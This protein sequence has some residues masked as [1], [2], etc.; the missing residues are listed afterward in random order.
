MRVSF[1][2]KQRLLSFATLSLVF[3]AIVSAT[4][5]WGAYQLTRAMAD[6]AATSS[7]Q[8]NETQANM[9]S[10]ALHGDVLAALQAGADKDESDDKEIIKNSILKDTDEHSNLFR[11]NIS[12]N[13]ALPLNQDIKDILQKTQPAVD[14]HIANSQSIIRLAFENNVAAN[15]SFKEYNNAYKILAGTMSALGELMDDTMRESQEAGDVQGAVIRNAI[16]VIMATVLFALVIISLLL[17]R[18][19]TRP[20]AKAV[21]L[22]NTVASGDLTSKIEVKSKDETGRMMQALK[23][24]N[25]SLSVIVSQVRASVESIIT[26]TK[27]MAEGNS[28][29]SQRIEKQASSLQETASSMEQLTATVKQNADNARQANQLATN[30]SDVALK[31]GEVVGEVVQTMV[32]ISASSKKIVDIISV[33][34]GI[35]FQTNIL[36]LN[37]AVEAA[38]AGEQ[39]RGFAVVAG[40][41][42]NLAQRSSAAAKEIKALIGDSVDRVN[43]GSKLV[44]KA[45]ATMSEI[46][47]AVK[48]VTD[49]MSEIAAAS[50]E[51]SS[52]IEQVNL[53]ITQMDEVTQQ[54]AALVEQAAA[55]AEAMEEQA[56]SLMEAV[57]VFKLDTTSGGTRTVAAKSAVVHAAS[58]EAAIPRIEP[59]RVKAKADMDGEWKEF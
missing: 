39:G 14:S 45:G 25:N 16:A 36:A 28:N 19:I 22:A 33:I 30:A 44:D 58:T 20:L 4:G 59:K 11:E 31:G 34:E 35:A 53:A 12:N 52:G 43:A 18:S 10:I 1:N 29:L 24:M 40:E 26:S 38:R 42:R 9:M 37:A 5:Y 23:D 46:V 54:N 41:V 57:S 15:A 2:I 3:V 7:A 56:R 17:I 51:Q 47:G 50:N 27:E 13:A 49:I 32:S 21:N 48:R 55:A 6:I 8:R